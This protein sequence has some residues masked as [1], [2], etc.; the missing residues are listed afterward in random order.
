[1]VKISSLQHNPHMQSPATAKM[2]MKSIGRG[3]IGGITSDDV[4]EM[5][6][7]V[8]IGQSA[9]DEDVPLPRNRELRGG[10]AEI[11]HLRIYENC[12]IW[13]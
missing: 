4:A 5:G 11:A 1:M 6:N 9:G 7:V 13:N 12:S 8:D 2:Q 10:G 3:R